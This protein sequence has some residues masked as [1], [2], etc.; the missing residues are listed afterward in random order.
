[1]INKG[2]SIDLSQVINLP[3]EMHAGIVNGMVRVLQ[4]CRGFLLEEE[5]H[6]TGNLQTATVAQNPVDKGGSV[7][8]TI[9]INPVNAQ[10]QPYAEY[11]LLG[12]GLLGPRHQLIYPKKAQ[13]LRFSVGGG[14]HFA[15]HTKGQKPN[16]FDER[17]L[18]KTEPLIADEMEKGLASL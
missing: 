11:V 14:I 4:R 9:V 17:A 2:F 1:M 5:P 18:N 12:T 13:A 7:E 3:K 16:P 15:K 8:G 6:V 10:G